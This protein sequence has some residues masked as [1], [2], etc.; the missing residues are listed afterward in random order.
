MF[1]A[2]NINISLNNLFI[3]IFLALLPVTGFT[4][5]FKL[6]VT[7]ADVQGRCL[8]QGQWIEVDGRYH[9]WQLTEF[10]KMFPENQDRS[11]SGKNVGLHKFSQLNPIKK[12]G[13]NRTDGS[14]VNQIH[15]DLQNIKPSNQLEELMKNFPEFRYLKAK[16]VELKNEKLLS[17]IVVAEVSELDL[18]R[19]N[20]LRDLNPFKEDDST[21]VN[22]PIGYAVCDVNVNFLM[23]GATARYKESLFGRKS[24]TVDNTVPL[25]NGRKSFALEFISR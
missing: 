17:A 19:L 21:T 6:S 23:D 2:I 24:L 18:H 7:T 1:R 20:K 22:V 5:E 8:H 9:S 3:G 15:F 16:K 11:I 12:I 13:L 4:A 10:N 14:L 25:K